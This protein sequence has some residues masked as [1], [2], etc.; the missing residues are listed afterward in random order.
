MNDNLTIV[1]GIFLSVI[2]ILVCTVQAGYQAQKFIA[3]K[4]VN[5]FRHGIYYGIVCGLISFWFLHE[6]GWAIGLKIFIMSIL[7]RAA[8][9]DPILN[10]MRDKPIWYN[11]SYDSETWAKSS[12]WLDWLEHKIIKDLG[13]DSKMPII[14]LKLIY[15]L[16]WVIYIIAIL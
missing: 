10:L 8:F 15:I 1:D 7:V 16:V 12:S 2:F 9:F 14:Y 5:H 11:G 4:P 3:N 6:F 13:A